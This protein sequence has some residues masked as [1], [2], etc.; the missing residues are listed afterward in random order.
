M[1]IAF[2][3]LDQKKLVTAI[4]NS[5]NLRLNLDER[6]KKN[7]IAWIIDLMNHW[8]A[9]SVIV[10]SEVDST[11]LTNTSYLKP[12]SQAVHDHNQ[13]ISIIQSALKKISDKDVRE[14]IE[15]GIKINQ[16]TFDL[17]YQKYKDLAILDNSR[18]E[19]KKL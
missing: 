19:F 5:K 11:F 17:A 3:E 18:I 8:K 13:S 4:V 15:Q 14:Q 10:K 2:K 12:I 16:D 9:E 6:Q 1:R 7:L